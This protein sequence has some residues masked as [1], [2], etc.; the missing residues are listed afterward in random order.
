M[1][2]PDKDCSV[3]QGLSSTRGGQDGDL[4]VL[5]RTAIGKERLQESAPLHR[6]PVGRHD[7]GRGAMPIYGGLVEEDPRQ[8]RTERPGLQLLRPRRRRRR[9]REHLGHRQA[10]VHARFRPPMVRIHNRP[11]YNSECH[12]TR[13]MGVGELNNSYEDAELADVHRRHRRQPVRDA[14]QLLPRPLGAQPAG[15]NRWTRRR[16][17]SRARRRPPAKVIFV[18]PRRTHDCRHRRAGRG[19]DNVLHLDIE[20]GTDIA[21]FN[22]L[23][24]YVVEQGWIDKDFIAK[25]TNGFD[26]AVQANRLSLEECSKIT[27]VPVA[28]LR[29]A[30]EWA[31]K[32]KADGK[33]PRTMHAYEKGIIW[34][35]DNYLIQS[36]LV[37]LVLATHNVGRRGTG[38]RAHGWSPG[39]LH[40]PAL[41]RR[42]QDLHRPGDHQG[43]G[44]DD[45][46]VGAA[47]TSRPATTRSSCAKWC[48]HRSQIVKEAM[49]K[50]RGA[51]AEQM[52]DVI[53]EACGKGG[54]FVTTIDLY[55]DDA[56]RGSAPAAARRASG[57]D[58][59]HLDERRAPDAPVREVH[60][61]AGRR[62]AGLPDRRRDRQHDQGDV[63]EGRQRR[64]G[65][66]AS[67]ASTGRPRRTRST[68]ASAAPDS[69]GR[70]PIDSQGGDTGNLATYDA[71]A[72]PG[73][74]GVQLP[75][76][77]YKDGKLIGTEM[78]YTDGKFDT[79]DG[80]AK[81]KPSPWPGLPKPV[82]EQKAKYKFWI[83][84]GRDQRGLADRL[85]RQV[86]RLRP[87]T[88]SD[89]VH[90]DQS[91]GRGEPWACNRATSSRCS[92]TTARPSRWHTSNRT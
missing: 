39:G 83:N 6:R 80:K 2:V 31:Y 30:A 84:N 81:F 76:K 13:E 1:I 91:R 62:Q 24:T 40:A 44:Q 35:N 52:V 3:N 56:R 68:T 27:G 48:S 22:G 82:A 46:L 67:R 47:T 88:L 57:R 26:A 42:Q 77:E 43:Q 89:G 61:P 54:L 49:T 33:P 21:L 53:Y 23:F 79:A 41:P 11:A 65:C 19:K 4:H 5:T 50:A 74:N 8:R 16:N 14:D 10:D 92:T 59:P 66:S 32:P 45:D 55:P 17:G 69:Q 37:D 38:V 12:A 87:R 36:A 64:D 28:K 86:Q 20:P 90:R 34:G 9:L 78:L 70:R 18:D 7:L 51:T 73:N 25:Y 63:P 85:S 58:E 75:I 15:R 29:Q 72:R 71:A 60:G